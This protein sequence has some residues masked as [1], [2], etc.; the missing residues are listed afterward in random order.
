MTEFSEIIDPSS[1]VISDLLNTVNKNPQSID[2]NHRI[3]SRCLK[4]L[5][6]DN[7]MHTCSPHKDWKG[8]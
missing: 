5:H 1:E 7:I 4:K 3:C 6:K 2:Q 8:D